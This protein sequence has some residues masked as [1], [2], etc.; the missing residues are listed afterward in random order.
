MDE[1]TRQSFEALRQQ[2]ASAEQHYNDRLAAI[3]ADVVAKDK[4][5]S[6]RFE[7]SQRARAEAI[8]AM[9]ERIEGYDQRNRDLSVAMTEQRKQAEFTL[10]KRLDSMNEFRAALSDQTITLLPRLEFETVRDQIMARIEAFRPGIGERVTEHGEMLAT[11]VPRREFDEARNVILDRVDS[12][13]KTS[14][15]QLTSAVEPLRTK[16][17]AQSQPNW[18]LMASAMSILFVIIAGAWMVTGLKIDGAIAPI[19]LSLEQTKVTQAAVAERVRVIDGAAQASTA[20]DQASRTDRSQL[21]DRVRVMEATQQG[22]SQAIS[23]VGN[24]K[25]Q[26]SMIVDRLQTIRAENT[27]QSAAL[28]EIETQ[29]CASDIMRNLQHAQDLR[30]FSMLWSKAFD[31]NT[32]YPTDNAYYPVICNRPAATTSGASVP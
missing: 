23:D 3:Q 29:F 22:R 25:Q 28:V 11:L 4:L 19:Q 8:E 12:L 13:R 31:Q 7:A 32:K 20:A 15:A 10:E 14:E 16:V 1:L 24:L 26:Y 27:R 21:N 30:L 9:R 18:A 2:L 17:D 5:Y 6:E